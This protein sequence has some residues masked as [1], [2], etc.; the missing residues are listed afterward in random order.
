MLDNFQP[1]PDRVDRVVRSVGEVTAYFRAAMQQQA[2]APRDGPIR[3]LMDALVARFAE[4]DRLDLTRPNNRHLA[5][6]WTA[7]LGLRGLTALP[8]PFRAHPAS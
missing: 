7:N 8:V 3:L 5:F 6:G 4:P 1:N 2:R